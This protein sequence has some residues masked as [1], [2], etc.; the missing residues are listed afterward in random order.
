M[1]LLDTHAWIWWVSGSRRLSKRAKAAIDDA[2]RVGV[3]AITCFE[4]AQLAAR[5]RLV[6]DRDVE[7]W[8]EQSLALPG[9]ELVPLTPRIATRACALGPDFHKDSHDRMIV[10]TALALDASL[11]TADQEIHAAGLVTTVW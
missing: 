7:L 3:S 1:I 10:A 2:S 4:V 11:V 8:L 5:G 9:F 6:L